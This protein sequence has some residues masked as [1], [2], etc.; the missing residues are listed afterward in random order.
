MI[1]WRLTRRP[2]ADLR[3]RGGELADGRWHTRGR[4]VVYA[5]STAALAALEVRVHLDL[6]FDLLPDDYVLMRIAGPDD[7]AVRTVDPG[8]LPG[9][10]QAPDN[11]LCRPVGDGWLAERASV[12]LRVPSAIIP[13]EQNVLINPLHPDSAR[14][15]VAEITPFVWDFATVVTGP[16]GRS[17]FRGVWT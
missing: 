4:P 5:A 1:L 9:G 11:Q 7:V 12:L 8:D 13:P 6:P 14:F 2:H 17:A 15:S 3:G 10:W 16:V